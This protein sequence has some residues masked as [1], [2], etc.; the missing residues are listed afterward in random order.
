MKTS[1]EKI[2]NAAIDLF[3]ERGISDV[4]I[5]MIAG[6]VCISRS[7]FYYYFKNKN[8]IIDSIINEFDG[9][10]ARNI[11]MIKQ[12][13]ETG[14]DAESILTSLFLA[15]G[16][17]DSQQGR[18]INRIIFA[19]HGYDERI[20]NYLKERFFQKRE[21][22]ISC[23]FEMMV[24]SGKLKPFNTETAARM[25]NKFFIASAL[26]DTFEYPFEK[27]E[28]PQCLSCLRKD[29]LYIIKRILSGEFET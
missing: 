7:T 22:R 5:E 2:I 12:Q 26:E 18:N 16:K 6:K 14:A 13:T 21:A 28:Q 3:A 25:L 1:K 9:M 29:C 10:I 11:N 15:F 23:I 24:T 17:E 19:N 4:P 20:G 27:Y 8:D